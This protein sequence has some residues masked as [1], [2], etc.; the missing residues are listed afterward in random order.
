[1]HNDSQEIG[2]ALVGLGGMGKTQIALEYCYRN[3]PLYQYIFWVKAESESL[4]Q[5]SFE[6]IARLLNLPITST[7]KLE[8]IV[9]LVFTCLQSPGKRWLLVFDNVDS[10]YDIWPHLP[11]SDNGKIVLTTRDAITDYKMTKINLNELKM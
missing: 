8:I 7:D 3:R 9:A 5:S 4:T 11:K 6:K 2:V 1:M 10:T